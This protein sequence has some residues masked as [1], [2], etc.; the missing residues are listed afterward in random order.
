MLDRQSGFP[1]CLSHVHIWN[2]K[3]DKG[4]KKERG[5][6]VLPIEEKESYRWIDCS[7][8]TK[9]VLKEAESVTI[10]ADRESDIYEKF[11]EVPDE[12][13][14]LVIRSSHNRTLYDKEEKLFDYLSS[15]C[16]KTRHFS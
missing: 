7:N 11:V 4:T 3:W 15:V 6:N 16:E 5:I 1:L 14:N 13:T 12:K 9:E 8:K 10:I 2:R